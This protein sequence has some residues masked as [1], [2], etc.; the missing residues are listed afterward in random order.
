MVKSRIFNSISIENNV[1]TKRSVDVS[2]FLG[3]IDWYLKLPVELKDVCPRIYSYSLD[4]EHPYISMEYLSNYRT[5]HDIYLYEDFNEAEWL[6]VFNHIKGICDRMHRYEIYDDSCVSSSIRDMYLNK[7]IERLERMRSDSVFSKFFDKSIII[8]GIKYLSLNDV[9]SILPK[10]V[11]D[12]SK[13]IPYFGIIHG[14]MC[15]TN[16]LVD[17]GYD[18]KLVDPRGK[19]GKFDIYG[20]FRYELA[21]LYHSFDGKYDFIIKDFYNVSCIDSSIHYSLI[22]NAINDRIDIHKIVDK[23]FLFPKMEEIYIIEA[24]LFLSMIPLHSE[25]IDHQ[26]MMLAKGIEILFRVLR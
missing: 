10:L 13:D 17:D 20:D 1:L 5:L 15:F 7:T 14:D 12:L 25:S 23:V 19:F 3:E 24:L 4:K 22:D 11:E 6:T 21:K 2:K 16:I 18:I 9:I 26:L 8:N